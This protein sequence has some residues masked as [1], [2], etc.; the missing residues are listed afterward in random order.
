MKNNCLVYKVRKS[1][2]HSRNHKSFV[3]KFLFAVSD[4]NLIKAKQ[5]NH[6]N[7]TAIADQNNK[8][9]GSIVSQ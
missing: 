1:V 6:T 3:C 4:S 8:C 7:I 2:I 9:H 5:L